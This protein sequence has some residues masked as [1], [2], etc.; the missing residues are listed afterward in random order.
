MRTTSKITTL[1]ATYLF[2]S[3]APVPADPARTH[4]LIHATAERLGPDGA[5]KAVA[6]A[7]YEYG[8]HPE[9]APTRMRA[10]LHAVESAL[11]TFIPA[12]RSAVTR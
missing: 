10:C 7:A 2:V 3:Q 8:R 12:P 1:L 4:E 11:H 6:E 9:T 5:A